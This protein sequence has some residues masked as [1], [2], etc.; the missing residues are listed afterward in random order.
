[1]PSILLFNKP[2]GVLSQ[3]TGEP[4]QETLA[5]YIKQPDYYAAGRLDKDSEG[6]LVLCK[7]GKLQQQISNPKYKKKKTYL[8]QVDGDIHAD[9]ILALRE[10]VQLKDGPTLPA[11]V[12]SI[13]DPSIWE[14]NP[15]IRVRK[16]I[17]TTWIE[18]T[19]SEGRNRQIRRMTAAVGFPTLRLIRIKIDDWELTDLSPGECRF[20]DIST[21]TS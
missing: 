19:L 4:G 8:V 13:E 12:H 2:F 6:L 17:P 9:A 5:S 16:N 10:G 14:R 20:I 18:L 21:S 1:M 11:I 15:P 7:D 3:F